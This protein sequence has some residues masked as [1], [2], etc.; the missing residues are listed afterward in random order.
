[1]YGTV[2]SH[3][4]AMASCK[5][6]T[7]ASRAAGGQAG[8]INHPPSGP[9]MARGMGGEAADAPGGVIGDRTGVG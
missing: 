6:H 7:R 5:V 1:M 8:G 4:I 3:L 2:S 9:S